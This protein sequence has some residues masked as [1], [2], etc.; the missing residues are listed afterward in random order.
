MYRARSRWRTSQPCSGSRSI[1]RASTSRSWNSSSPAARRAAAS[2]NVNWASSHARRR[3][4]AS[5]SVCA[6]SVTASR[7]AP[8]SA[9]TS[10]AE[11]SAGQLAFLPCLMLPVGAPAVSIR[12]CSYSS[13]AASRVSCQAARSTTLSSSL[14]SGSRQCTPRVRTCASASRSGASAG[15]SGG[16]SGSACMRSA[17]RSQFALQARASVRSTVSVVSALSAR[18]TVR[19]SAG[20][21][22]SS[23][24]KRVHRSSNAS[25]DAMSSSTCTRGGSPAS[26]GCSARMRCANAWRVDTAAASSSSSARVARDRRDGIAVVCQRFQ[27]PA[28][29]VAQLGGGL[30]GEGHRRDLAHGHVALDDQGHDP[31][32]QRLG[33]ARTRAG[34][35]EEGLVERA[36][37]RRPRGAI[38]VEVVE[39]L[40]DAVL[41]SPL[42]CL[43]SCPR[44]RPSSSGVEHLGLGEADVAAQLGCLA[45]AQPLAVAV[46]GAA[47]VGVGVAAPAAAPGARRVDPAREHAAADAVGDRAQHLV[48]PG[49]DRVGEHE[50]RPPEPAAGAHVPVRG[51]DRGVG[52]AERRARAA[53]AYTGSCSIVPAGRGVVAARCAWATRSCS[54][55][56]RARRRRWCR[57]GRPRR[58][59]AATRP[60]E[61]GRS[62]AAA[63]SGN[64]KRSS[65]AMGRMPVL[66]PDAGVLGEEAVEL[67]EDPP[68]VAVP[69]EPSTGAALRLVRGEPRFGELVQPGAIR[70][71]SRAPR[72]QARPRAG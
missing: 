45:L 32:D 36:D 9:R 64:P 57:R 4:T 25:C 67:G 12:I 50:L 18:S 5:D 37:D 8:I 46:A 27:G 71:R 47:G 28:D 34:L 55:A 56:P 72:A 44:P 26:T 33:L 54:R 41:T 70:R 17:T 30:L 65:V 16:G 51:A 20:S 35:D 63:P 40:L 29:P 43:R 24:T 6:S 22:S 23:S 68:A 11:Q 1:A 39:A 42:R 61:S 31:V 15:A 53:C 14:S 59:T 13:G 3:T 49:V 66:G 58:G 7:I 69:E 48:D 19:S 38:L 2:R 10:S 62:T 52:G 21:S 60:S